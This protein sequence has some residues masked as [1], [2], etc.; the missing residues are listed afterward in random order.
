MVEIAPI[1]A[2][3]YTS[4]ELADLVAPPYDVIGP[5]QRARLGARSPH[6]VVHLDLPEGDGDARY[7]NA[8]AL[9][10]RWRSEGVMARDQLP[11]LFCYEQTF[12][13]PGGGAPR[14]RVGF[15]ALVRAEP[16]ERRAVLPHE[17]TLSGPKEDRYRLMCTT[18]AALSPV[19]LLYPDPDRVVAGALSKAR[20]HATFTTDDGIRHTLRVLADAD[21]LATIRAHLAGVSAVIA[22]G[23]HRYETALRYAAQVDAERA[24]AGL[25]EA[26]PRAAHRFVLAF[27]AAVEDPGLAV[28]PT[29]RL[30]HSLPSFDWERAAAG[31]AEWFEIAEL[32]SGLDAP[33]LVARLADA[34]AERPAIA[35]VLRDG[36]AYSLRLR[37][38]RDA[39]THPTL[40]A[41]PAVLRTSDVVILHDVL[42]EGVLGVS[43]QAQLE[44]RNITYL[45]DARDAVA[46]VRGGEGDVLFLLNPTPVPLVRAVAEAGEVMPQKST[47]FH[48]K[49]LT[50]LLVHLLDPDETV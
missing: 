28:F 30:L 4:S 25:A 35:A 43:R 5:E 1:R 32:G 16:Y 44:Q 21:A 22:D 15:F 18:K 29:H 13:P 34:G 47:Y 8:A 6:N 9:L 36:R 49:V 37:G 31:A 42:L 46:R 33:A 23:H 12:E 26:S 27:L 10:A 50:G 48:P 11:A 3:R 7:A 38:D 24:A 45:K 40:G 20:G 41:R 19:F 17:R 2:L 39:G 14:T